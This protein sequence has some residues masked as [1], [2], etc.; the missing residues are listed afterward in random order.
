MPCHH[1]CMHSY[2]PRPTTPHMSFMTS[3]FVVVFPLFRFP[4]FRFIFIFPFL[5]PL[6]FLSFPFS[7]FCFLSFPFYVSFPFPFFLSFFSFSFSFYMSLQVSLAL[8]SSI[9]AAHPSLTAALST[10]ASNGRSIVR[11]FNVRT[12]LSGT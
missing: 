6:F 2:I 1:F 10:E 8:N 5:F 4:L 3:Y 9:I 7:F 11:S 12:R